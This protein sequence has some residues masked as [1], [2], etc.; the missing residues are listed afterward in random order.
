MELTCFQ[1][2]LPTDGF[3][4]T[5][6]VLCAL[7]C[8]VLCCAVCSAVLCALLSSALCCALRSA[9]L[10]ALWYCLYALQL[11]RAVG[12][13]GA[14]PLKL[15]QAGSY[16]SHR[17]RLAL[18]GCR[19]PAP[20]HTT[21]RCCLLLLLL[22]PRCRSCCCCCRCRSCCC[23]LL[24][25]VCGVSAPSRAVGAEGV[26]AAASAGTRRTRCTRWRGRGST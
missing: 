8:C 1:R 16:V 9:V 3:L 6:A 21:L 4:R 11:V 26:R 15:N 25:H 5:S 2:P 22:L 17:H 18:V 24:L 13:R 14:F 19:R 7:L 23:C 20:Q 10:C 12:R